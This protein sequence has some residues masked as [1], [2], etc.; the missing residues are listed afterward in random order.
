MLVYQSL[1]H[2]TKIITE[3]GKKMVEKHSVAIAESFVEPESFPVL[4]CDWLHKYL[5]FP[6]KTR[7]I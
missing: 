7:N 5:M 6:L 3:R 4:S 1:S 2:Y